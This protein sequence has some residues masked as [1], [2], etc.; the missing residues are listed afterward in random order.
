MS[1]IQAETSLTKSLIDR[2]QPKAG[3]KFHKHNYDVE[4]WGPACIC[5]AAAYSCYLTPHALL[6]RTIAAA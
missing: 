4:P 6:K 1:I 2:S 3:Q 5:T